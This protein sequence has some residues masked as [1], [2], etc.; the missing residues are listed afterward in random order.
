MKNIP[1]PRIAPTPRTAIMK[2]F[3]NVPILA[4]IALAIPLTGC[5]QSTTTINVAKD[6]S[7]TI[8][9]R[10]VAGEEFVALMNQFSQGLAGLLGGNDNPAP[11]S[12]PILQPEADYK[13][14]VSVY[15][16]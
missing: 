7:G 16:D 3:P 14:R 15:G 10:T 1:R 9:E 8:V 4:A 12:N 6:G 11:P 2:L 13:K 5:V